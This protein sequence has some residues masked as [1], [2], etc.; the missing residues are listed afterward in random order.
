MRSDAHARRRL[1]IDGV[2]GFRAAAVYQDRMPRFLSALTNQLRTWDVTHRHLRGAAAV[3]RRGRHAATPSWPTSWRRSILLRYVELKSQLYRLL[4]IMK[5]RESRY[6]T[7]IREFTI[8]EN[9]IEVSG[10]F[11]SAEAILSGLAR[12]SG[13]PGC[14]KTILVVDD[15]Y[16]LL[17]DD[18]RDARAGRLPAD[19]PQA[20]GGRRWS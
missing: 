5:M 19:A 12:S 2:E 6:D 11:E 18:L 1:F 9:G 14:M 4:S 17:H 7:S 10:S 20:T 15:E 13:R 3:P 16:D 8:T